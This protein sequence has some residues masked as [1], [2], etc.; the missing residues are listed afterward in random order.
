MTEAGVPDAFQTYR[1]KQEL[2]LDLIERALENGV[3]FS[4]VGFGGPAWPGLA[5]PTR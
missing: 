5:L 2:A 1:T 4:W 3:Q